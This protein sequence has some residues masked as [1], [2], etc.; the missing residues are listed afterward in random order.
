MVDRETVISSIKKLMSLGVSEDEIIS[1]LSEVGIDKQEAKMLLIEAKGETATKPVSQK[2]KETEAEKSLVK[3]KIQKALAE[4]SAPKLSVLKTKEKP[5][6]TPSIKKPKIKTKKLK[7]NEQQKPLVKSK[8][9]LHAEKN[10]VWEKG[11]LTVINERLDEIED[12][13]DN[14]NQIIDSKVEEQLKK[15]SEEMK[16]ELEAE[17]EK[18]IE[19]INSSLDAKVKEMTSEIDLKLAALKEIK[20]AVSETSKK[21]EAKEKQNRELL[22]EVQIKMGEMDKSKA[23]LVKA[24]KNELEETKNE[25]K[26]FM[27][28]STKQLEELDDRVNKALELESKIT[29]GLVANTEKKVEEI[30]LEKTQEVS[31]KLAKKL[32]LFGE[33]ARKLDPKRTEENIKKLSVEFE[34]KITGIIR[35]KEEEID[36]LLESKVQEIEEI[37]RK[38][39]EDSSAKKLEEKLNAQVSAFKLSL[40]KEQDLAIQ[41]LENTKSELKR[42]IAAQLAE[43]ETGSEQQLEELFKQRKKELESFEKK[44]IKNTNLQEINQTVKELDEFKE[45]F[46]KTIRS[47]LDAMKAEKEEL[48][49]MTETKEKEIDKRINEIDTK[50]RELDSFEKAFAKEMGLKIEELNKAKSLKQKV[51]E[52]DEQKHLREKE[53]AVAKKSL[54]TVFKKTK[55]IKAKKVLF[56]KGKKKAVSGVSGIR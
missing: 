8:T 26:D 32:A 17:R 52:L 44:V 39:E 28:D 36:E 20:I 19:E 13:R 43:S 56:K 49:L 54:K 53:V 9:K 41:E 30:A 48:E 50:I 31:D 6:P 22:E 37:K 29:E 12:I 34:L 23:D 11:I 5:I 38:A 4:Q 7:L 35:K 27:A 15:E 1:N 25:S 24:L 46:V 51:R 18:L 10:E 45:Q 40:Q 33:L 2:P 55:K 3:E 16:L 21:A 42:F 47:S 14:I